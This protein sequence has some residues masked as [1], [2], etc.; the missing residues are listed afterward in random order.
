MTEVGVREVPGDQSAVIR[1]R[2]GPSPRAWSDL[3]VA[4]ET[5][6]PEGPHTGTLNSVISK[7]FRTPRSSP[8][9]SMSCPHDC[10]GRLPQDAKRRQPGLRGKRERPRCLVPGRSPQR[11]RPRSGS[12]EGSLARAEAEAGRGQQLA[13]ERGPRPPVLDATGRGAVLIG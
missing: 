13:P 4:M 8:R 1:A 5:Q 10:H 11:T 2:A 9:K 7:G 3:G 12:W 6:V